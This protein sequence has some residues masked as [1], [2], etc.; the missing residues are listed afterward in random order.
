MYPKSTTSS[1]HSTKS[2]TR[3]QLAELL[4]NKFRTKYNIT[5]GS[6]RQLDQIIEKEV[7]K[8]LK[9]E[10]AIGQKELNEINKAI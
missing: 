7:S 3:Q 5:L 2:N 4:I 6:E 8:V 10:A 1:T 9:Q